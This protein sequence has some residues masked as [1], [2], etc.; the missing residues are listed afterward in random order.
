VSRRVAELEGRATLHRTTRDVE[1][2]SAGKAY[3]RACGPPLG[4]I[5]D[6]GHALATR[7]KD[8]AGR[9]RETVPVRRHSNQSLSATG[10]SAGKEFG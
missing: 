6:A 5:M 9:L 8:T 1:L 10:N 4:T 7:S 2:M 3:L